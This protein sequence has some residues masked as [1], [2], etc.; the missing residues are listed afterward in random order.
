MTGTP[1]RM[2]RGGDKL[3][4]DAVDVETVLA[5]RSFKRAPENNSSVVLRVNAAGRTVLL[6]GDIERD[7]EA[8]LAPRLGHADVLKIPHHG[9]LTSS[10]PAF[11]AALRP[12][13]A[14]ASAGRS[15]HFGHPVP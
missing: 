4:I 3:S 15:N 11:L 1:V 13:V 8:D 14:I 6:T 2:V 10:T 9:S 12:T 7:A 5:S